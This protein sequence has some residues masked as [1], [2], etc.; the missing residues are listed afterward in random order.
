MT[1]IEQK[2]VGYYFI[3]AV[4]ST[5][6][7]VL[8]L[9]IFDVFDHADDAGHEAESG[10]TFSFLSIQSILAFLMGFGWIGLA[11]MREYQLDMLRSFAL[12]IAVGALFTFL[13]GLLMGSIKKLEK[14][15]S[16][17]LSKCVNE[18][19][20][21]YTKFASGGAGQIQIV[22]NGR[23]SI[24]NAINVDDDEIEAFAQIKVTKVDKNVIYVQ[25]LTK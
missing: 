15:S 10:D 16:I 9:F 17:N 1:L 3:V 25:K 18:S 24:V 7:F 6:L 13:S 2:M 21:A 4:A 23:L 12:A 5:F 8:K 19:G 20:K 14:S 22:V 11:A